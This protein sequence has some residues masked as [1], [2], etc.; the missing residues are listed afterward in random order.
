[1]SL[2]KVAL[3][4]LVVTSATYAQSPRGTEPVPVRAFEN[5][6][7]RVQEISLASGQQTELRAHADALLIP[8]GNDLEGRAPLEPVTWQAAGTTSLDNRGGTPFNALLVE[9]VAPRSEGGS[10]MPPELLAPPTD[11]STLALY[12]RVDGHRVRTVLD[13]ARVL[14]TA[15]RLPQ[16]QPPTEPHHWHSREQVLVYLAGGELAGTG[17]LGS[18]RVRRGEFAILPANV[19]HAFQNQGNDPVEFLMISPK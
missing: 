9:I 7:I 2:L 4:A 8:F 1:M 11:F 15:H 16:F 19:P 3:L 5:N 10:S 14:V 17:Q 12:P 18:H 6:Q 13:N